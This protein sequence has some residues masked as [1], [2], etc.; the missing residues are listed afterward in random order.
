MEITLHAHHAVMSDQLRARAE[1]MVRKLAERIRRPVDATIR[2]TQDGP[3]RRVEIV[4]H[5]ARRRPIVAAGQGRTY[6]PAL[7]EAAERMETQ[8]TRVKRTARARA[9]AAAAARA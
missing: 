3:M 1:R 8:L 5:P 7:A 9:A 6:G 4:L 2:F